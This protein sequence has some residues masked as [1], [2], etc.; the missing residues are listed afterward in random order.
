MALRGIF[1]AP[2]DELADPRVLVSLAERAEAAGWEGFFLWDH[3]AYEAP[4][5]A[6]A[7]PWVAM[8]AVAC[9]TSRLKIGALVTPLARRRVQKLA[10]ECVTLDQLS[11]GRLVF[12][13]GLGGDKG[14]EL[15]RFGE[16]LDPRERARLLDDG[17]AR[18]RGYWGGGLEPRPVAG[19]IPIWLAARW[20]ND[21]PVR[22]AARFDGLFPIDM[23]DPG[24]LAEMV[25]RVRE[26]RGGSLEGYDV[27]VTN[28]AGTDCR[29]WEQAGAT[30]CLTGFGP[31]PREAEV[32][33]AIG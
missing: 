1:L 22:R 4:V 26:L 2:F 27:V 31:S 19:H 18:L 25:A 16:E 12:G 11:G 32:I 29:P 9:A 21:R 30:W 24:D 13:A 6:L 33:A 17:L 10:R 20:P 23:R 14:G 7:D 8:A 28:P 15:S 3:M 5:R